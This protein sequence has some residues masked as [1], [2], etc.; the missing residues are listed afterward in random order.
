MCYY[1]KLTWALLSFPF[2][3][4][5]VRSAEIRPRYARDTLEIRPRYARDTPEIQRRVASHSIDRL[6]APIIGETLHMSKFTAYDRA[7]LLVKRLSSYNMKQK[8]KCAVD[9]ERS[10]AS[11]L[12]NT[13]VRH[14]GEA[15]RRHIWATHWR[16]MDKSRAE[17]E[18]K[19]RNEIGHK[20]E[21][22]SPQELAAAIRIQ[23]H[24]RGQQTRRAGARVLRHIVTLATPV[25]IFVPASTVEK[26]FS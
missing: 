13:S 10:P 17:L 26:W 3:I 5:I 16:R 6:Q 23:C 2:L 1:Y 19:V 7:G 11:D 18:E 20:Y 8:L 15:F 24:T 14:L 4:F 12:G 9:M 25:G 22:A 21:G